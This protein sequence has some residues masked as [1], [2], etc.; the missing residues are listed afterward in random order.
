[1][2]D[3]STC[4]YGKIDVWQLHPEWESP[5][6]KLNPSDADC[7]LH[8][9]FSHSSD[10]VNI[11]VGDNWVECSLIGPPTNRGRPCVRNFTLSRNALFDCLPEEKDRE[12]FA[13]RLR[14]LVY[15]ALGSDED[16]DRALEALSLRTPNH[17]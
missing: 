17:S 15:E 14:E 11:G 12:A 4:D 1:M 10:R 9:F 5:S 2:M 16:V 8:L 7:F 3:S 13:D 6:I